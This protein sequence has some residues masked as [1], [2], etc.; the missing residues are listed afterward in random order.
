MPPSQCLILLKS[1][2]EEETNSQGAPAGGGLRGLKRNAGTLTVFHSR[3][4]QREFLDLEPAPPG[5]ETEAYQEPAEEPLG[6]Q[7]RGGSFSNKC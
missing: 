7:Q 2:L 5:V 4:L 6:V 3:R 1:P